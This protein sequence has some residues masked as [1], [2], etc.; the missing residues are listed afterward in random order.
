M[1]S[2]NN[3]YKDRYARVINL[4]K[5]Q[6]KDEGYATNKISYLIEVEKYFAIWR[7]DTLQL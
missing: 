6:T 3:Y 4:C 5:R 7:L 1:G 2:V